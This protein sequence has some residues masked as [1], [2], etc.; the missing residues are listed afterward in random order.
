MHLSSFLDHSVEDAFPIYHLASAA[1]VD[2]IRHMVESFTAMS[3][4]AICQGTEA[5]G[6]GWSNI[7]RRLDEEQECLR[8]EEMLRSG[9]RRAQGSHEMVSLMSICTLCCSRA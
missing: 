2:G 9:L 4:T 5:G 6:T 3:G 7:L 8:R 1:V